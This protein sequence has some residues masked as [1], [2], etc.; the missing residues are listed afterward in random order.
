VGYMNVDTHATQYKRLA[1]LPTRIYCSFLTADQYQPKLRLLVF[2]TRSLSQL[3]LPGQPLASEPVNPSFS[4][5][6]L[7]EFWSETV[8]C[9]PGPSLT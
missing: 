4:C 6:H 5:Q 8:H 1:N 2:G 3:V 7:Y 9:G